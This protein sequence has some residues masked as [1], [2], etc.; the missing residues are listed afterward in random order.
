[1][2][3]EKRTRLKASCED[4]EGILEG[5]KHKYEGRWAKEFHHSAKPD[6]GETPAICRAGI[7]LRCIKENYRAKKRNTHEKMSICKKL[8]H[9]WI[10][11]GSIAVIFSECNPG[12][13]MWHSMAFNSELILSCGACTCNCALLYLLDYVY[14]SRNVHSVTRSEVVLLTYFGSQ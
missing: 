14:Y 9:L 8:W 13:S 12:Y 5:A 11:R 1:M 3:L 2:L 6:L 10:D 7:V 4:H